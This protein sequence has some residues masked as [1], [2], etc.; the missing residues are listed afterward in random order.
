MLL[1]VVVT[2]DVACE[3]LDGA[4]VIKPCGRGWVTFVI[5]WVKSLAVVPIGALILSTS[6]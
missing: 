3:I 5:G 6:A 1:R 2:A 4:L